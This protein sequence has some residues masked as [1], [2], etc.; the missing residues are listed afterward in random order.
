MSCPDVGVRRSEAP[1]RSHDNVRRTKA[2][3]SCAR[4]GVRAPPPNKDCS[5]TG[6]PEH[7]A[8]AR[9]KI[10]AQ[11][12]ARRVRASAQNRKLRPLRLCSYANATD[13]LSSRLAKRVAISRITPDAGLL[14]MKRS[15][16]VAIRSAWYATRSHGAALN[17]GGRTDP[18]GGLGGSLLLHV[19]QRQRYGARVRCGAPHNAFRQSL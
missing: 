2:S 16:R 3:P 13:A 17:P 12:N 19:Q 9:L 7:E 1:R 11:R 8:S 5:R 15:S 14:S 10:I 4:D 6:R 18:P